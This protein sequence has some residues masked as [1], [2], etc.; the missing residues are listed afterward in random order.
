MSAKHDQHISIR[1]PPLDYATIRMQG[2]L[3]PRRRQ[4]DVMT[5]VVHQ[6]TCRTHPVNQLMAACHSQILPMG[7]APVRLQRSMWGPGQNEEV[8]P[9]RCLYDCHMLRRQRTSVLDCSP[10]ALQPPIMLFLCH[11]CARPPPPLFPIPA[12]PTPSPSLISALGQ[13]IL[14]MSVI[15]WTQRVLALSASHLSSGGSGIWLRSIPHPPLAPWSLA[16]DQSNANEVEQHRQA[17]IF[18][19]NKLCAM[20]HSRAKGHDKV[21]FSKRLQGLPTMP[22]TVRSNHKIP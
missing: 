8:V 5:F 11:L 13:C 19:K 20:C 17:T 21:N 10:S 14:D 3:P 1:S 4:G 7:P 9:L 15:T 16:Q 22:T 18:S 2:P 6:R 12:S